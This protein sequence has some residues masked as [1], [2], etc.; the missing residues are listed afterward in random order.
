M[1]EILNKEVLALQRRVAKLETFFVQPVTSENFGQSESGGTHAEHL[2]AKIKV[3]KEERDQL[4]AEL[5]AARNEIARLNGQTQFACECGGT[6]V[7]VAQLKAE[8]ERFKT[9]EVEM[10]IQMSQVMKRGIAWRGM[11]RNLEEIQRHGEKAV[12]IESAKQILIEFERLNLEIPDG[13]NLLLEHGQ[14]SDNVILFGSVCNEDG[15]RC[16]EFLK[17]YRK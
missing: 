15:K 5:K 8:V 11:G 16:V 1:I 6:K 9:Q 10:T 14:I 13:L 12:T 4:K 2:E 3:M 7:E 17:G